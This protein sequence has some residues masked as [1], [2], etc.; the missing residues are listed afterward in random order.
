MQR[1]FPRLGRRRVG[2]AFLKIHVPQPALPI[3]LAVGCLEVAEIDP[4][5]L[6]DRTASAQW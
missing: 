6:L 4:D 2:Q 1:I 3:A 5:T